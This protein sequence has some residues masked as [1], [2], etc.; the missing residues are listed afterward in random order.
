MLLGSNCCIIVEHLELAAG[1]LHAG[2]RGNWTL[3]AAL[4]CLQQQFIGLCSAETGMER[5]QM[6]IQMNLVP[7]P[8]T[9]PLLS[10]SSS[11]SLL[12]HR[13]IS[14]Q[15]QSIHSMKLTQIWVGVFTGT[16]GC[17]QRIEHICIRRAGDVLQ[18]PCYLFYLFNVSTVKPL[19][20]GLPKVLLLLPSYHLRSTCLRKEFLA[21]QRQSPLSHCFAFEV[22][23]SNTSGT[24]PGKK[25]QS[26]TASWL[27]I[28][29]TKVVLKEK[30]KN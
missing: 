26:G 29:C 11:C 14:F 8:P 13:R 15:C 27:H 24:W 28:H 22:W 7:L 16:A 3:L 4:S 30:Q 12:K 20:P 21:W 6:V 2:K 19:E 25:K 18:A 1:R 9:S 5:L 10:L 23:F 17:S